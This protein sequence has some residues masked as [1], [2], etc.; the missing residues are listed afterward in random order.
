MDDLDGVLATKLDLKSEFGA[1]LDNVCDAVAHIL[2]VMAVGMHYGGPCALLSLVAAVSIL[3]RVVSRLAWAAESGGGSPTN[4]LMRHILFA[5]VVTQHLGIAPEP[6]L[7]AAFVLNT[8]SMQVSY[9]LRYSIRSLTNSAT[10]IAGVN[11]A[12][13][14]SWW[15]PVTAP[16][17]AACFVAT[18]LY[19]LVAGGVSWGRGS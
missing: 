1:T 12:L 16:A 2:V 4:E 19:S 17:I 8:V 18:Y 3:V 5:L 11:V 15:F 13:G 7:A 9:P 6:F 10:A 14:V